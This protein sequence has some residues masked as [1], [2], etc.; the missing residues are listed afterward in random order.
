ME[1]CIYKIENM[2]N[3]IKKKIFS[4]NHQFINR[5]KIF[6]EFMCQSKMMN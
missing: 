3:E 1:Y 6:S 2:I 5:L 4:I